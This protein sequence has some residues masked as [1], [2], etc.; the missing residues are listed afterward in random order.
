MSKNLANRISVTIILII[1]LIFPVTCAD[2]IAATNQP[3]GETG[4]N[5]W[6][7]P[8]RNGIA[9]ASPKLADAWGPGG[10]V[11]VW[12]SEEKI[13]GGPKKGGAFSN[14]SSPVVVSDK[15]YLYVHDQAA[16]ADR[17]YCLDA[18][19]GKTLWKVNYPGSPN[20]GGSSTPYVS[21]GKVYAVGTMGMY[22]LNADS[23]KEI[24]KAPGICADVT[25]DGINSSPV[26]VDGVLVV[27]TGSGKHLNPNA[28][29]SNKE[30]GLLKGF[31]AAT[32]KELW[33]CP[34][35]TADGNRN[36]DKSASVGVWNTTKGPRLITGVGKLTCLNP[37]DGS[38]IWQNGGDI[39]GS[40]STPAIVGDICVLGTKIKGY[41]LGPDKA[42]EMFAVEVGGRVES[43]LL[44][45]GYI[46]ADCYGVYRCLDLTGK[47]LWQKSTGGKV[48]SPILADSK[49]Y[50]VVSEKGKLAMFSATPTMPATFFEASI[51]V[52]SFTSP[53]FYDGKLF[54][55]LVDGVACYDLTKVPADA[56]K[57]ADPQPPIKDPDAAPNPR[58][59]ITF[60]DVSPSYFAQ[61]KGTT[62]QSAWPPEKEA[63]AAK[64]NW[65]IN[66]QL[67]TD[68]WINLITLQ[69][70]RGE[71]TNDCV[72]YARVTLEAKNQGKIALSLTVNKSKGDVS[73]IV[74]WVNGKN[75][76]RQ[77]SHEQNPEHI[78]LIVD[79]VPGKNILLVRTY[80]TRGH[81]WKLRMQAT[82]L[83]GLEIK[84]V[85]TVPAGGK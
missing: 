14:Y 3:V 17:V 85:A 25:G 5:Q 76:L 69:D 30:S 56:V 26:I 23:G 71:M 55:R 29:D 9:P 84:Q 47:I 79:M 28:K 16:T 18:K 60:V 13:P 82:P 67:D 51:P 74:A 24:W 8:N 64:L 53:A 65:A 22:C 40:S 73:A 19:T 36:G 57:P 4:W 52:M 61:R 27:F 10:P 54:V 42:E 2:P 45:D 81:E 31:D 11:Q 32:G 49:I 15:V 39:Y 83:D 21:D 77:N 58:A 41:R 62:D 59:L 63:E 48:S 43:Y 50:H 78:E 33:A 20:G 68:G 6:R 44:Y 12:K 7:G 34:R 70:S 66:K 1:T 46:Y 38:V 72:A 37:K 80:P 75:V 35:A